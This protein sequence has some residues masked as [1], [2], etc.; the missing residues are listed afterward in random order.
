MSWVTQAIK[1]MRSITGTKRTD[2]DL[3]EQLVQAIIDHESRLGI[4]VT[5]RMTYQFRPYDKDNPSV[6]DTKAYENASNITINET[7]KLTSAGTD[8]V[9][10]TKALKLTR[11]LAF[12][13]ISVNKKG[14]AGF[15]KMQFDISVDKENVN[16]DGN[17]GTWIVADQVLPAFNVD[18]V[19]DISH[20]VSRHF[21]LR[22]KILASDLELVDMAIEMFFIPQKT[23]VDQMARLVETMASY[24]Y[25]TLLNQA[26]ENGNADQTITFLRQMYETHKKAGLGIY[27]MGADAVPKASES[28]VGEKLHDDSVFES[29]VSGLRN[30]SGKGI[31]ID[32]FDR[33]TYRVGVVAEID[34]RKG[35][36]WL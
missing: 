25:H 23:M 16:Q 6:L 32:V 8:G 20:I 22:I 30:K 3:K 2:A 4:S 29:T 27:G 36:T 24:H 17:M 31:P 7:L 14:A 33:G 34:T 13:Q 12:I 21:S 10:E 1:S 28:A 11:E 5:E 18:E 19:V 9:V 35:I 15:D 26:G